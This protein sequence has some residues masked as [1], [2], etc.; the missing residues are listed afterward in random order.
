MVLWCWPAARSE[1]TMD[2]DS[3]PLGEERGGRPLSPVW[4]FTVSLMQ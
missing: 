3:G 4:S 1:G 2:G